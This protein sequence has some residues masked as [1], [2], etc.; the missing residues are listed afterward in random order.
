M[1]GTR[2]R[3]ARF[4]CLQLIC[5]AALFTA[6]GCGGVDIGE[7]LC[8]VGVGA[9][10][11]DAGADRNAQIGDAAVLSGRASTDPNGDPLTYAWQQTSGPNVDLG[12]AN[13]A[14]TSFVPAADGVYAFT[15]TVSDGCNSDT[16]TVQVSVGESQDAGPPRADAGIDQSVNEG[17]PICLTGGNSADPNGSALAY[18]WVQLSGPE[19]SLANPFT[20]APCLNAP[21]VCGD[22]EL[23]F[24]L[25]VTNDSD[26][27]AV[28]T[29]T[30]TVRDLDS[31]CCTDDADCDDDDLCT[32][33]TCAD[34]VCVSTLRTCDDDDPCTLDECVGGSCISY[35]LP[36]PPGK[37]CR[38]G[39][40]VAVCAEDFECDDNNA[41]SDDFCSEGVC[42]N[43][44]IECP[45]GEICQDGVCIL[46]ANCAEPGPV[47]DRPLSFSTR[48]F[49]TGGQEP[50]G[51][52]LINEAD[53][54]TPDL[55][56]VNSASNNWGLLYASGEGTFEPA[57]TYDAGAAPFGVV[58][59]DLDADGLKDV[60]ITNRNGTDLGLYY[61]TGDGVFDGPVTFDVG[62]APAGVT[63][64]DLDG[65][66]ALDIV[67]AVRREGYVGIL[68]G[69]GGRAF[70][71]LRLVTVGGRPLQVA[72]ADF[73]GDGIEDL[74]VTDDRATRAIKIVLSVGDGSFL[75]PTEMET[76]SNPWGIATGDFNGDSLPDLAVSTKSDDAVFVLLGNGDG[77]FESAVP[78][79]VDTRQR[80]IAAGDLDNDGFD[81]IVAAT[82]A[83]DSVVVLLSNG[84]GAF[85]YTEYAAGAEPHSVALGDLD[86]DG[87]LDIVVSNR[88][89]GTV[90]ALTNLCVEQED[91][92][93]AHRRPLP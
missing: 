66:G 40:C 91:N 92:S 73:N 82:E 42:I 14:E 18:E 16:D 2:I 63:L 60:V 50:K 24:E 89:E 48:S 10:T 81:D 56:V 72:V 68:F 37:Q 58:A 8:E 33:D 34:G 28:D 3:G 61:G 84:D 11:A 23:A 49:S 13:G 55:V 38:D 88:G 54:C 74:A 5:S 39:S 90:T 69:Q 83:S 27:R 12:N 45:V 62:A 51:I 93:R 31:E 6:W 36:C 53:E 75:I 78:Q 86:D 85:T 79:P 76:G 22:Q 65:N 67:V 52:A 26:Y 21:E 46:Q 19:V 9:P 64:A 15:L 70:D 43:L 29:V 41:C 77:T 1:N 71:T 35:P 47:C 59:G 80:G 57:V 20:A 30:I 7:V 87:D 17:S 4:V 44:A 32:Q 25:T